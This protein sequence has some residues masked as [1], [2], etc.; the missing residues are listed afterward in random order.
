M[1][2]LIAILQTNAPLALLVGL[3]WYKLDRRLYRIEIKLGLSGG[4]ENDH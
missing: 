3:V 2:A 1:E 4:G